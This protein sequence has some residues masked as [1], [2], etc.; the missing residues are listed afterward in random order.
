MFLWQE[1]RFFSFLSSFLRS[2]SQAMTLAADYRRLN[3]FFD[4]ESLFRYENS[5]V[6]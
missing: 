4:I 2:G 3:L 1:L 5:P 6:Y